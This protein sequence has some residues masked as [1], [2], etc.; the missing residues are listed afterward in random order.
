MDITQNN[1]SIG[2]YETGDYAEEIEITDI[3]VSGARGLR[4]VKERRT[5]GLSKLLLADRDFLEKIALQA[6]IEKQESRIES[7]YRFCDRG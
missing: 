7:A 2:S 1:D 3:W 5:E 4:Q 6:E